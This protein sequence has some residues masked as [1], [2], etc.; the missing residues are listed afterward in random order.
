MPAAKLDL[1]VIEKGAT[2]RERQITWTQQDGA[3]P[4]NLSGCTARMHLRRQA[5]APDVLCELTTDNARIALGGVA[6]TIDLYIDAQT[7]SQLPGRSAVYDLEI[8]FPSGDVV[9]V[10]EGVAEFSAEVTR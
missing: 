5:A 1:S 6:G 3:T 7:T 9:R 4:V 8:A 2:W 10:L